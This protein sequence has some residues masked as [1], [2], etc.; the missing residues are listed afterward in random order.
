MLGPQEPSAVNIRTA[1]A[2]LHTHTHRC[3]E[4]HTHAHT[5]THADILTI[6]IHARRFTLTQA[7]VPFL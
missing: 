7:I 1:E 3:R 6:D 2:D 4:V 5:R